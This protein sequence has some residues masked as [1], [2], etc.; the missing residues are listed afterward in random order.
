MSTIVWLHSVKDAWRSYLKNMNRKIA[1]STMERY[2]EQELDMGMKLDEF[3]EAI[4]I[5]G[6]SAGEKYAN[7]V[8]VDRKNFEMKLN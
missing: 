1:P 8:M 3:A 2:L 4:F 6:F 7:S 5:A